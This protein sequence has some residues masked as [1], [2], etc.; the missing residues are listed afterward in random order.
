M[1][2]SVTF[3]IEKIM[4]RVRSHKLKIGD[5]IK[6]DWIWTH[7]FYKIGQIID[8]SGTRGWYLARVIAVETFLETQDKHPLTTAMQEVSLPRPPKENP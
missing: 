5:T 7:D 8:F 4:R 6:H 2:Q 1:R 3:K